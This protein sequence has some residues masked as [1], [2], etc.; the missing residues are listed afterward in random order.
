MQN[1]V[2]GFR[3][4]T[5]APHHLASQAGLAVLREGGNALECMVAMAATI[6]VVY[7]HMNG[8]GGDAFWLVSTPGEPPVGIQACGPAARR[9]DP[10]FYRDRGV[11]DVIPARGPLAALTV[12]GTVDGWRKAL[13]MARARGGRLRLP[14]LLADAVRL[15]RD[16]VAVTESQARLTAEKFGELAGVEGFADT[17]LRGGEL[18]SPGDR[19][20]QATLA[21]TLEQLGRSGLDDFYRGDVARLIAADLEAAGSPVSLGDL[22]AFEAQMVAPLSARIAGAEL[23]NMPPPT[24]GVA[25][26]A[27]LAILDRLGVRTD[28]DAGFVHDVVEATK[29]AFILRNANVR[30]PATMNVDPAEF[31][32]E[33]AIARVAANVDRNRAAPWPHPATLG[34]TIWMGAVDGDGCAVS[35][36]Q[37]VFWEFGSGLVSPRTGVLWQNRGTSFSLDETDANRLA[38]GRLPFHTLNPALAR[39]EDGRTMVYGTMGGEGQPQTQ[40]AIFARYAWCG[41]PLQAAITAPRWLLGRTWGAAAAN[42]KLEEGFDV[43]VAERLAASGHDVEIVAPFSDLMGHAGAI[44]HHAGGLFE[45]ASDPRANGVAAAF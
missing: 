36:I 42:L 8:I 7:P 1:T 13:V 38:P 2:R 12:A 45:G 11:C 27:I 43:T 17:F 30:D 14:D 31:L 26:L 15:A 37:S 34:D 28:D 25:S 9:A 35:F 29:Q 16:G 6:A 21:D 24:Q 5:T 18:P 44:V 40:A 4:M 32:T 33:A 39:F 20:V 19:L 10:A 41:V 23:Y 3:G 22:E